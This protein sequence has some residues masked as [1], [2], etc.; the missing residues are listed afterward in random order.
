MIVP[1]LCVG[2]HPVTL[3]VTADAERPGRR[4]HA[5]RGNDQRRS[6]KANQLV[7]CNAS[8]LAITPAAVCS[9]INCSRT[10]PL[11]SMM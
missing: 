5:E 1:T 4:Y 6:A 8:S 9:P 10:L 3:C 2:M 11:L 7:A